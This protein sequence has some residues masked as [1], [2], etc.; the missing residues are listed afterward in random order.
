MTCT[1]E[2]RIVAQAIHA[3]Y[4]VEDIERMHGIPVSRSRKH[5]ARWRKFDMLEQILRTGLLK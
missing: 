2:C 5:I 4:G 3:G 1:E